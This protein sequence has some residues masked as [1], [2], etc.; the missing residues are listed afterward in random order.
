MGEFVFAAAGIEAG[1]DDKTILRGV[2]LRV[3]PGTIYA[4]IGPAG[5]GKSTFLRTLSRFNDAL[6]IFWRRGHVWIGGE[7]VLA[8]PPEPAASRLPLLAQKAH[9]YRATVLEN[10]IATVRGDRRLTVAEKRDLAHRVL[11]PLG[12]WEELA[13]R[14]DAPVLDLSL[15]AQRRLSVARL[16]APEEAVCLLADEPLRDI[17]ADEQARMIELLRRVRDHAAVLMV[18]HNQQ[19]VRELADDA[20]LLVDGRLVEEGAAHAVLHHPQT[21]LGREFATYGNAWPKEEEPRE[22]AV[23]LVPDPVEAPS[24]SQK[25][26]RPRRT[27]TPPRGFGWLLSGELGGTPVPGLLGHT[28][29]DLERLAV[30]GCKVLVTLTEEPFDPAMLEP[31]G[32]EGHH[33]PMVDMGVPTFEAALALCQKIDEW[34]D[35]EQTVILHCKA[36]LGRTGTMLAVYLVFRSMD[37]EYAI[38]RVRSVNPWYIQSARQVAFIEH[39]ASEIGKGR[40]IVSS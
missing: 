12:L 4:L 18:T 6:P 7:D 13:P 11:E 25:Q 30:L 36:G 24:S 9:L 16:M 15:G 26:P 3:R 40:I 38:S 33:V 10:A 35:A 2:D 5:V 32:I 28:D 23:E 39:F 22:P 31:W 1:Y 8:T 14:L 20:G 27:L 17:G 21:E 19:F 34:R 37:A 29:G